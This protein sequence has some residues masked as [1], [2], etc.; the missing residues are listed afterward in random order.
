MYTCL[1]TENHLYIYVFL[2][3]N[4]LPLCVIPFCGVQAAHVMEAL[5]K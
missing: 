2:Y 5:Q 3:R 1:E 4:L